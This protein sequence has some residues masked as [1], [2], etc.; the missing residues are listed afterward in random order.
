MH[1][2]KRGTEEAAEN[3]GDMSSFPLH[4]ALNDLGIIFEFADI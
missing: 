2:G 1:N 4:L 3:N